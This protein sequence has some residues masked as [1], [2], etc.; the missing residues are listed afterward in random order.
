MEESS[1]SIGERGPFTPEGKLQNFAYGVAV[2]E[3]FAGK[4]SGLSQARSAGK[5]SPGIHGCGHCDEAYQ[6]G[7]RNILA[8]VDRVGIGA[9]ALHAVLVTADQPSGG[10]S[11]RQKPEGILRA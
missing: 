10:C 2:D 1:L 4:Q 3:R 5:T 7:I 9:D 8:E 11:E 6:P